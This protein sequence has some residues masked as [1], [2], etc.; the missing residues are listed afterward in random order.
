MESL[1]ELARVCSG[2]KQLIESMIPE[3]ERSPL[4]K[5]FHIAFSLR[6]LTDSESM[7]EIYGKRNQAAFSRLKGRLKD[8]FYQAI[9]LQNQTVISEDIRSNEFVNNFKQTL[10]SRILLQRK[11]V[12][13]STD[14]IEKSIVKSMKYH[15]TENV[16]EQSRMLIAYYN[17]VMYN[18]YKL[19]KY[20]AIQSEYLEIYKWEIKSENYYLDLQRDQFQSLANPTEEMKNKAY[21]YYTDLKG[22][23]GIRSY[24]FNYN[25]YRIEASYFEYT[26]DYNSLLKLSENALKEFNSPD[27]R[28]GNAIST[29]SLRK[30]WALIQ[31]EQ[32]QESIKVG[33]KL[34]DRVPSGSIQ[35]YRIAHYTLKAK[36]Y[37]GDYHGAIDTISEMIDNPKFSKLGDYFK[38]IFTTTL[39]YIHL[40][41]D[42]GFVSTLSD[43]RKN[44]PEFKLGKFL[45]TT[46]VFSKDKRGINVSILLMHIGFLLQRKDY[47]AI[48]DRI[49]SLNQYA[50]RY[51][52][53]DD[54]FRSNCMIKMVIQMAKADFNPIRTKR[55]TH[56]LREELGRVALAGSGENIEIE[57][58][59]FEVLWDIMCKAL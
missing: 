4:R 22:A 2:Q 40:L 50:Y 19:N 52:R 17:G 1:Y 12:Q 11:A 27:F 9:I 54:S 43:Q 57:I 45:N 46:P 6:P 41:V 21:R 25:K 20:K 32:I 35:W 58:I 42:S 26:K 37:H 55:Y 24:F 39:G 47:N 51:L 36:L 3:D 28:T 56:D 29:I 31:V 59:P 14:I 16:L 15:V 5:L 10:I 30:L 33:S 53:K 48:I 8:L 13:L 23:K 34:M 18:K 44:L 38:E 7:H 49:D